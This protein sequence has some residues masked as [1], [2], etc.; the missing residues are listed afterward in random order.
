[1][2]IFNIKYISINFYWKITYKYKANTQYVGIREFN[3]QVFNPL[4]NY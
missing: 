1:M 2:V 3:I 4:F